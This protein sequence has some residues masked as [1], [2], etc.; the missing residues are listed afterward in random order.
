MAGVYGTVLPTATLLHGHG[1]LYAVG[2]GIP[3]EIATRTPKMVRK[4]NHGSTMLYAI[5]RIC[6]LLRLPRP[7]PCVVHG[8]S[9]RISPRYQRKYSCGSTVS[10]RVSLRARTFSRTLRHVPHCAPP[11]TGAAGADGR[12]QRLRA[13]ISRR[14][15]RAHVCASGPMRQDHGKGPARVGYVAGKSV[16]AYHDRM[17]VCCLF[18]LVL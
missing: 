8:I 2:Y 7:T 15:E 14:A 18:A 3:T 4:H 1:P 9:R 10:Q 11:Q 5:C 13:R 17:G 16:Q 12:I 6:A